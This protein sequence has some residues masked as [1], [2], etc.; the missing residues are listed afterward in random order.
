MCSKCEREE[1]EK[2]YTND[3]ACDVFNGSGRYSIIGIDADKKNNI[4]PSHS[5]CSIFCSY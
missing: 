1:N 5:L 3:I 4:I 2:K